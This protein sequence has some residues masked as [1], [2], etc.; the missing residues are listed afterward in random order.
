MM[1]TTMA[2]EHFHVA[3]EAALGEE[4]KSIHTAW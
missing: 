4:S 1:I 3:M 2:T